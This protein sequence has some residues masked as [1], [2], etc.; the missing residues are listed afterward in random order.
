YNKRPRAR[1]EED[2][3]IDCARQKE[4]VAAAAQQQGG[5][6]QAAP[7]QAAPAAPT[8]AQAAPAQVAPGQA[9]QGVPQLSEKQ[10]KALTPEQRKKLEEMQKEQAKVEA[11]NKKITGV[12]QYMA[13]ARTQSQA[14]DLDGAV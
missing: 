8:Q 11:E 6:G 9:G 10:M 13:Q 5:A 4:R 3:V 7:G 14:G 2:N 1:A 12:N